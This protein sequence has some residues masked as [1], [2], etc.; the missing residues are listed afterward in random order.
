MAQL[1]QEDLERYDQTGYLLLSQLVS[2]EDCERLKQEYR[3]FAQ[4]NENLSVQV[5]LVH[6]SQ[7]IRDFVT[8][9]PQLDSVLSILGPNVC[10]THQQFVCKTSGD[11]EV[12]WH[13]DSGYGQLEPL[14]DLTIW[15]ALD[16]TDESNGCLFILPESHKYGLQPHDARGALRSTEVA[17]AGVAIPM[18]QGDALLFNGHLLHRSPSNNTS[19]SRNALYLRYCTPDVVMV[20]EGNK[21]V[22]EDAYSWMVA[23]EAT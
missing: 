7:V 23:G 15:I 8:Q 12:F 20:N 21:P 22:L 18:H 16:D 5:Q 1:T 17:E 3:R 6:R 14:S 2:R 19:K 11:S 4:P 13:Q 9:G 10:F